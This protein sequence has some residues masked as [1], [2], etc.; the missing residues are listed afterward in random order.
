MVR[1]AVSTTCAAA[2]LAGLAA[3]PSMIGVTAQP[4]PTYTTSAAAA[5]ADPTPT[6]PSLLATGA[7][8]SDMLEP[9][10]T[11]VE[12]TTEPAGVPVVVGGPLLLMTTNVLGLGYPSVSYDDVLASESTSPAAPT[13]PGTIAAASASG[14]DPVTTSKK[15]LGDLAKAATISL[16]TDNPAPVI[17]AAIGDFVD[18]ITMLV[19]GG[20]APDPI[21]EF[22]KQ[23]D[24]KL[25]AI[26]GQITVISQTVD[27]IVGLDTQILKGIQDAELNDVLSLMNP[28]ERKISSAFGQ[29]ASLGA[30]ITNNSTD[31]TTRDNAIA[32][33]YKLLN[34]D[35]Q[36]PDFGPDQIFKAMTTYQRYVLGS[37]G[38]RGVLSFM[39]QM[40][41]NGWESCASNMQGAVDMA[42]DNHY[43]MRGDG[44][45][46]FHDSL[47][48]IGNTC[49]KQAYTK[50]AD[51]GGRSVQ[52]VFGGILTVQLKA[53]ALLS[54]AYANDPLYQ[55]Q[56][57]LAVKGVKAITSQMGNLWSTITQPK[58]VDSA[59]TKFISLHAETLGKRAAWDWTD[60]G[61]P[62]NP[63]HSVGC[64]AGICGRDW[65]TIA[66]PNKY[67][68]FA[69]TAVVPPG[70]LDFTANTNG[71]P[72]SNTVTM[73]L[74]SG[75]G[76]D[77]NTG[78]LEYVYL[79][80]EPEYNTANIKPPHTNLP[81]AAPAFLAGIQQ[82]FSDAQ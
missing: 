39:P 79:P 48:W 61:D 30:T 32:D 44:Q 21:K 13:P 66:F 7:A 4:V 12:N 75:N 76:K 34:T 50:L 63:K 45:G 52:A 58:L 19:T 31:P 35:V 20:S 36:D 62:M 9:E 8:A 14:V 65:V 77:P 33:V 18:L 37:G 1:F 56:L 6:P 16:L 3:A 60:P 2:A 5:F 11:M 46:P 68:R 28:V 10:P 40:V 73:V 23:V 27:E 17:A 43:S 49:L 29:L 57:L 70:A 67:T 82:A 54:A 24:A 55:S 69:D 41:Q 15:I 42:F 47:G 53:F 78:A 81:T 51:D 38:A 26:Q 72:P 22:Q 25:Q 64:P 59:A 71:T 80:P 74:Y